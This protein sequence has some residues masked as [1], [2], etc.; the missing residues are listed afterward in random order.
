MIHDR[1]TR[2]GPAGAALLCLAV[3]A[4]A[5]ARSRV[6]AGTVTDA[7]TGAPL[8][9]ARI[10]IRVPPSGGTAGTDEQGRFRLRLDAGDSLDLIVARIGYA[11]VRVARGAGPVPDVAAALQPLRLPLDPIIVTA[12]RGEAAALDA[13]AAVSVVDRG[14]MDERPAAIGVEYARA[15]PGMD[16]A[17]KG[18]IQRPYAVRGARGS[19]SGALLTLTDGRY[20][21]LPSLSLNVPYLVA[22]A[23]EDLDRV[24][25]VRGPGAALYGPGADR[26]V[27]QLISRSPFASAGGSADAP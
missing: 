22:V 3:A 19:I 8:A 17:S 18:L 15:T 26:G 1:N 4:P 25:V 9:G 27:L 5:L 12:I 11:P 20:A 7:A 13:P 24:E 16:M 2:R 23:D 21:E 14:R 10:E 6:V